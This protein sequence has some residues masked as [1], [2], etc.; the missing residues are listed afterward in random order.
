MRYRYRNRFLPPAEP[1]RM[2]TAG[3]KIVSATTAIGLILAVLTMIALVAVSP[4]WRHSRSWGFL[5]SSSLGLVGVVVIV[6]LTG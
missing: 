5:P 1:A 4:M 6:F 2:A 3:H